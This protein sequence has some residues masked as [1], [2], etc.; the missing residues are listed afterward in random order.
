MQIVINGN[1]F[2]MKK[3]SNVAELLEQLGYEENSVAV[4]LNNNFLPRYKWREEM[5]KEG[6]SLEIIA[7][8]Q[9]G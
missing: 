5:L 6:Q 8:M 4:T 2:E 1:S 7:P 9:G 3:I